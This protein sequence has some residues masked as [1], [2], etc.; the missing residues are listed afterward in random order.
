MMGL[1]AVAIHQDHVIRLNQSLQDDLV[2]NETGVFLCTAHPAKFRETIEDVLK[3]DL[4]LPAALA[5]VAEKEVMSAVMP[6]D[7]AALRRFLIKH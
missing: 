4:E 1:V 5:D 7:F 2:E 6:A 3:R